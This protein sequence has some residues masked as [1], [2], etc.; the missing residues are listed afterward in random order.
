MRTLL[1]SLALIFALGGPSF[2]T[3]TAT[4]QWDVR[5]TGD[6][7]NG[8][9]FDTSST[10]TDRSQQ[11]TAFLSYTDLVIGG[12]TTQATSAAHPFDST[13]PGNVVNITSGSGCTV[14]RRQIVS[15]SGSTATF[16]ATLGT[17]A[18]T[19]VA[20]LGGAM[21]NFY[22]VLTS[23]STMNTGA[24]FQALHI[25]VKQGTY[26]FV[27][28]QTL[29]AQASNSGWDVTG[30]A[31]THNDGGTKPLF[32]TSTNST[33]MFQLGSGSP[34]VFSNI[35]FSNTASTRSI[36]FNSINGN[37]AN[38][39]L[40]FIDCTFDGF[41]YA[42]NAD[43]SSGVHYQLNS[44]N[45]I[46]TEV[47]NGTTGGMIVCIIGGGGGLNIVDSW[48]HD[49]TGI[50]LQFVNDN[51]GVTAN[52]IG[53]IFS[54]NTSK[55]FS[56]SS[57]GLGWLNVSHS[58]FGNNTGDGLFIN[59]VQN[60]RGISLWNTIF[61]GNGGWGINAVVDGTTAQTAFGV[62][63]FN[64]A[65]G[66]NTSGNRNHIAV[67]VNDKTL[68]ANPW[69]SATNFA[70]NSTAGGG[71]LLKAAGSPGTFPGGLTTSSPDIGP[72]QSGAGA[73]PV[74]NRTAGWAY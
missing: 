35:S 28:T 17:A 26:T 42:L 64:N 25:H 43:N 46:R 19:C 15:V 16:D 48:I 22:T 10:G 52:L 47:K 57:T 12:T 31:V 33:V 58:A 54:A 41:T 60:N 56:M 6:D 27:G 14:G 3:S 9:G 53:S 4:T 1:L 59:A 37:S 45:L 72:V 11:D 61:Y 8:G 50:G 49:N 23:V 24:G 74:V 73:A 29:T 69:T 38:P 51:S 71:A 62:N 32:T 44:L 70:L 7:T 34:F 5:T 21:A 36:G 13:S 63:L 39:D 40:F 20:K 66:S 2:A 55:G 18:S 65:Y 67:G 68:S 30:Y